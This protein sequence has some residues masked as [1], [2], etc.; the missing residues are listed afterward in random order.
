M[1]HLD[2]LLMRHPHLRHIDYQRLVQKTKADPAQHW[3]E[4]VDACAPVIHT[5]ALRLVEDAPSARSRAEEATRQVFEQIREND[6]QVIRDYIGYG[7]F[8]SLLA[9][10][11]QLCPAV[12]EVTEARRSDLSQALADPDGAV[13]VLDARYAEL[14][15]KEGEPF[16]HA[17]EQVVGLL[18]RSDRLLLSLRYEQDLTLAEADQILRLGGPAR[19]A[20][21]LNRLVA[22][23][24]PLSA[25]A[26]AWELTG[27][28][29]QALT[30]TVIQKIFARGSM[31]TADD[32]AV[33]PATQGR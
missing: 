6:F 8:P 28:Q 2:L 33:A 19:V 9:R 16:L 20:S 14:L 32:A 13:E 29:R 27:E 7:K 30:R 23:L 3:E 31:S 22:K 24:Q 11:T 1:R 10:L 26:T 12:V 25:V 15:K 18:H 4:F 21:L 17:L 5:V